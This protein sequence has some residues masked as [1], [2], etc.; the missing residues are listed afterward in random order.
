M[1]DDFCY[2][3]HSSALSY[4]HVPNFVRRDK[5]ADGG[6]SSLYA[7]EED[8]ARYITQAG[9]TAG[10]KGCVW[11]ERLWVDFDSYES[12]R[13]AE[14]KLKELGYDFVV[15]DSGGR[16]VHVGILRDCRPSHTLPFQDKDWVRENLADA[17]LSIYSH[18]HLFRLPGTVHATTGRKKELLSKHPGKVLTLPQWRPTNGRGNSD[19]N[20]FTNSGDGSVFDSRRVM[21]LT[22]PTKVGERHPTFNKLAYALKAEGVDIGAARWW[23]GET[24]KMAEEPKSGLELDQIVRKVYDSKETF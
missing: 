6:F 21:H 19:T 18:L 3:I 24:N 2:V 15:Y 22:V 7:V 17:D 4:G 9:T 10:F 13:R 20:S 8:T 23:V 1:Q 16:G 12:G 5:I 11:S 14:S